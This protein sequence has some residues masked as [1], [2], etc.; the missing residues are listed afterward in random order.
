MICHKSRL[1]RII[2]GNNKSN[3]SEKQPVFSN[4]LSYKAT[5]SDPIK[6]NEAEIY[7]Y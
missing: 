1:L 4:H 2:F 5:I 7:V 6:C 3:L